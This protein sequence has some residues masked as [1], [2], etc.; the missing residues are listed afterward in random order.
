MKYV[1]YLGHI[2]R[3]VIQAVPAVRL[4]ALSEFKQP[5]TRKQ[6]RSFLSAMIYFRKFLPGYVKLS[7][8]LSPST[9]AK[10]PRIVQRTEDILQAFSYIKRMLCHVTDL[11]IPVPSDLF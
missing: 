5:E 8:V 2:V 7:S 9:S 1:E 6:L 11:C 10:A 4:K 3:C